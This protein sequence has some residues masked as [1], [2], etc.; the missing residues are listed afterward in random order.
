M[1]LAGKAVTRVVHRC[2]E[3]QRSQVLDL[4]ACTL[5]SFPDAVY[6]LLRNTRL[7]S[8]MLEQNQISRLP[9]KFF[10]NFD[11][12]T[13]LN[14]RSNRLTSLPNE[15]IRMTDL[16]VLD[17][18]NNR[19]TVFPTIILTMPNLQTVIAEENEISDMDTEAL[20]SAG[21]SLQEVNLC[22]NPL[23]Q[24]LIVQLERMHEAHQLSFTITYSSPSA[25]H[26]QGMD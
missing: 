19:F 12:L 18:S 13:V 15:V 23:S 6:F 7:L 2:H 11:A 4:S 9:G 21:S 26:F 24:R 5:K 22:K 17:I 3:G 20:S 1:A 25:D 16:K 10:F 14:L 8:C